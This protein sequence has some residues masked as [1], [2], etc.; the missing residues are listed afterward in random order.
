MIRSFFPQLL[1]LLAGL[2]IVQIS[3]NM[4]S[5]QLD[6]LGVWQIS[7]AQCPL[8]A[9]W[10]RPR[11]TPDCARIS[12]AR[13]IE[14]LCR[15]R[16]RAPW[17]SCTYKW[18]SRRSTLCVIL[19]RCPFRPTFFITPRLSPHTERRSQHA[20]RQ[21]VVVHVVDGRVPALA[22]GRLR[23]HPVVCRVEQRT[24]AARSGVVQQWRDHHRVA[25]LPAGQLCAGSRRL[26]LLYSSVP[27]H[28]HLSLR[29]PALAV[30]HAELLAADGH[31]GAPRRRG[32]LPADRLEHTA[33][34]AGVAEPRVAADG[35]NVPV[36]RGQVPRQQWDVSDRGVFVPAGAALGDARDGDADTGSRYV[37]V[38]MIDDDDGD[39]VYVWDTRARCVYGVGSCWRR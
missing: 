15:W 2:A 16:R 32:Q 35:G 31:L 14:R 7:C 8:T 19:R 9:I 29:L 4:F 3:G 22:A 38:M 1:L 6:V 33:G 34:L 30:R 21:F 20:G 27:A 37:M 39:C 25:V 23:R 5:N 26:R 24:V 12:S 11:R 18:P 28:G 36:Q 17:S 13:T 10:R